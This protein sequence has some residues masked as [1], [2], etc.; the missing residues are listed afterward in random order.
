MSYEDDYDGTERIVLSN[1][2]YWVEIK[3][4]LSRAEKKEA[5]GALTRTTIGLSESGA[6][7]PQMTPSVAEYRDLMVLNSVVGWNITG[8]D[9]A[10]WPIDMEH[11]GRLKDADFSLVYKRVDQVNSA[12]TPAEA[13]R[14]PGKG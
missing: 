14:F 12:P 11:I 10:V 8:K 4:C 3:T 6:E 5:E 2:D 13:Q 9:G 1:P 7:S